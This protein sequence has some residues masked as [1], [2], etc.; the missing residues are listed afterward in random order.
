MDIRKTLILMF[1]V[2]SLSLG[3]TYQSRGV[4]ATQWFDSYPKLDWELETVRLRRLDKYLRDNPDSITYIAYR[5]R[6]KRESNEMKRRANRARR[7]LTFDLKNDGH[8]IIVIDAGLGTESVT[9][10][11][12]T[13]KESPTPNFRELGH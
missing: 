10:I 6:N 13:Q 2:I 5:S 9:I 8:R 4:L 11:E 3:G 12:P 7:Y 1:T